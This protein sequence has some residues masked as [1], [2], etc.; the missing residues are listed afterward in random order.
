MSRTKDKAYLN[1]TNDEGAQ[2]GSRYDHLTNRKIL[3][4]E[5]KGREVSTHWDMIF[6]ELYGKTVEDILATLP[7]EEK[8]VE[9]KAD[10]KVVADDI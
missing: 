7:A 2:A 10:K 4:S 8:S 1:F 3:I 5:K 9:S 6:P